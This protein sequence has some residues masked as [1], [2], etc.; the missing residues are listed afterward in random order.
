MPGSPPL[1]PVVVALAF[2]LVGDVALLR[3]TA[4]RF[5]VGLAAFL[6]AHVVRALGAILETS[7]SRASV[8]AGGRAPPGGA[9]GEGRAGHRAPLGWAARGGL[10]LQLVLSGLVLVAAWKGDW[11]LLLGQRGLRPL[12][13]AVLGHDRFV[14][15]RRWAS[16]RRSS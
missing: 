1:L 11:L 3:A 12:S 4:T 14:H 9:S 5:L 15:E 16:L 10:R 2:C 13:D 7:G 8:A 6:A